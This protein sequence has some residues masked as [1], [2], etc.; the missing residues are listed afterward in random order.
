MSY[1]LERKVAKPL[2]GDRRHIQYL[3]YSGAGIVLRC[4][5]DRH[6][7]TLAGAEASGYL[8]LGKAISIPGLRN[9]ARGE[10]C[11]V[12]PGS[13]PRLRMATLASGD[14]C[15][16]RRKPSVHDSNLWLAEGIR[17]R[18]LEFARSSRCLRIRIPD[19]RKWSYIGTRVVGV[20]GCK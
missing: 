17:Y 1:S 18:G 8:S 11:G 16:F 19:N 3:E 5:V 20:V 4:A 14:P 2:M 12:S 13:A 7:V 9:G 15:S 10:I 6:G